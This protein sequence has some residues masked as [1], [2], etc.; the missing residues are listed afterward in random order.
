MK[1]NKKLIKDALKKHLDREDKFENLVLNL[2]LKK[3]AGAK[4]D[5]EGVFKEAKTC[6]HG[7]KNAGRHVRYPRRD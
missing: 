7:H 1:E 3:M 6:H 5:D 4:K 2:A